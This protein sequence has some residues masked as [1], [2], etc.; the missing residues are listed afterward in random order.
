MRT[1]WSEKLKARFPSTPFLDALKILDPREWKKNCEI[2]T[3]SSIIYHVD[4]LNE[5]IKLGHEIK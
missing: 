5:L 1:I 4:S 3:N 2:Y